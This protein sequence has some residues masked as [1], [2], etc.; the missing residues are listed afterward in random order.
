MSFI[1]KFSVRGNRNYQ[2]CRCDGFYIPLFVGVLSLL[3]LLL[4]W[5]LSNLGPKQVDYSSLGPAPELSEEVRI[6]KS[7]SL[8]M[9][10]QFEEILALR[11][12]DVEDL[13]LLKGAIEYQNQ[14]LDQL[15]N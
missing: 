9:E 2:Q 10:A 7:Q 12:P 1:Q 4:F 5:A 13:E 6:L 8:E 3:I 14:Y 11:D 15:P